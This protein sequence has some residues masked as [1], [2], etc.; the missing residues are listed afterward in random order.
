MARLRVRGA[1]GVVRLKDC[2]E[3]TS[4]LPRALLLRFIGQYGRRVLDDVTV[5]HLATPLDVHTR[6]RV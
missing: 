5:P 2:T 6:T 1:V 4:I 3:R